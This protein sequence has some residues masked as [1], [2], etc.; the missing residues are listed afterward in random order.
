MAL[1]MIEFWETSC[2]DALSWGQGALSEL[3]FVLKHHTL[4]HYSLDFEKMDQIRREF[5]ARD[6]VGEAQGARQLDGALSHT[7][8]LVL[9]HT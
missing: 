8:P 5:Q 9:G 4:N 2:I 6:Q 7:L 1:G 3:F